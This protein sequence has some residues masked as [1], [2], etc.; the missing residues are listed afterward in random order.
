MKLSPRLCQI[1]AIITTQ[2]DHIW[3]C[4]CDHGLL[5]AKLLQRAAADTI[6]FVDVVDALMVE[7][8]RK[9]ECFFPQS[10]STKATQ[11]QPNRAPTS[12]WQVHC[13]NVAK[14]PLE[15]FPQQASHLVIIAGVGGGLLIELVQSILAK[16]SD[17]RIEF[18]LCPVHHHYKVRS[19]LSE[20]KLALLQETLVK[21]NHRFYEIIHLTNRAGVPLSKVGSQM[22][23][24][25]RD[26]DREYLQKTI[27]HYQRM[28]SNTH[29]DELNEIITAYQQLEREPLAITA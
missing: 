8:K 14:L 27:M 3:D 21:D 4:C 26:E 11:S 16:H 9:L 10:S 25:N 7:L 20:M 28:N 12:Q 6:H 13:I 15:Q 29:N 22:W 5:G 18:I 1:D 17:R 23:D 2:Y 24:L 19:A